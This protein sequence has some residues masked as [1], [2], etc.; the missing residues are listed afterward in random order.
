M[1][2]N[3]I[4]PQQAIESAYE[5]DIAI[6]GGGTTGTSAAYYAASAGYK[7]VLFEQYTIGNNYASSDGESRMFR[8]MY[9]DAT[10]ARLAES[11]L[12]MWHEIQ[13]YSGVTL[14]ERDGLLFYGLPAASVEG[15]LEQCAQVMSSLGVPYTR[16]DTTALY[17]NYPVFQ[18]LPADYFG[19]SQPSSCMIVVKNSLQTFCDLAA[20]AGAALLTNCPATIVSAP[21]GGP[22]VISSPQGLFLAKSLIMAPGAWSNR[23]FS[24]FDIQLNLKIWQMTVVFF[25]VDTSLPWP[26]WYEF[27]PTV[28]NQQQLFYGFPPLEYPDMIKVSADFTNDIYDDP[29]QCTYQPDP[30]ILRAM[31]NFVGQRFTGISTAPQ[32][33]I[34]CLYTMTPDAQLVLDT[35]PNYSNVAVLTGESGRAFKYTPLFGRILVELATTGKS[36]YDISEF[37]INRPGIIQS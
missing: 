8:I 15:N 37:S 23:L 33:P 34:T 3:P 24:A 5:V 1:S 12:G 21:P 2:T 17:Q 6:I 14:L 22:Y 7:T 19:L 4:H 35:L 9:S 18:S 10:M 36:A 16:Y 27:G 30:V 11:A 20:N 29:S 31:S 28:D 13:E 25:G 32:N 26:M